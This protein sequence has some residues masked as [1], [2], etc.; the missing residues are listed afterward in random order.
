[1][2]PPQESHRRRREQEIA[3][4]LLLIFFG[5]ER[6]NIA[7]KRSGNSRPKPRP[8]LGARNGEMPDQAR[9]STCPRFRHSFLFGLADGRWWVDPTAGSWN[10]ILAAYRV[11]FAAA[12]IN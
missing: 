6:N 12:R 11:S 8:K 5:L 9:S 2:G 3:H 7:L 4:R 10:P 1:M